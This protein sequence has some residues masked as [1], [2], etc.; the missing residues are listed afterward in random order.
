MSNSEYIRLITS[1]LYRFRGQHQALIGDLEKLSTEALSD[2][3]HLLDDA[4][5]EIHRLEHTFRP[6]PGGPPIHM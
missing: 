2:L 3:Y 6:F 1:L 5:R 4:Q